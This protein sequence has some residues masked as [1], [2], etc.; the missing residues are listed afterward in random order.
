MGLFENWPGSINFVQFLNGNGSN[1]VF[2]HLKTRQVLKCS[3]H[4]KGPQSWTV[5]CIKE[6]VKLY[7]KKRFSLVEQ[8]ENRSVLQKYSHNPKTG[9]SGLTNL[10]SVRLPNVPIF[11]WSGF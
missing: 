3:S 8:F 1:L 5:V 9:P 4:W 10:I 11:E 6:G 2:S 7:D